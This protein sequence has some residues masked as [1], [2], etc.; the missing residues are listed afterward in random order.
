MK[1]NSSPRH[2]TKLLDLMKQNRNMKE[3]YDEKNVNTLIKAL[4]E[5]GYHLAKNARLKTN[6]IRKFFDAVKRIQTELRNKREVPV[7]QR[8]IRLKPALAYATARQQKQLQDFSNVLNRAIDMVK[9][10]EDFNYFV[11][12]V[13][14]IVAYH[15][16][17]GGKD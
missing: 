13:E 11:E 10:K 9:D 6:Q 2:V 7:R 8:V 5:F 4:D 16:F 3:L 17:H 15:K 12:F 1:S 14:G